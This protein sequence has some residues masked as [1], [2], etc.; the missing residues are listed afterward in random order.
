MDPNHKREAIGKLIEVCLHN[1]GIEKVFTLTFDN[2]SANNNVIAYLKRK[3]VHWKNCILDA[4]FLHIRCSAHIVNLIV[5]EG[6]KELDEAIVSIRNAVRYVRSSPSRL[7]KFKECISQ[8]KIDSKSLVCLD[9]PTKW[10]STYLML[11]LDLKFQKAFERMGEEDGHYASYF[12]ED[13]SSRKKVGPPLA[14]HWDDAKVF[15][16]FLKGFYDVTL[17]FSVSLHVS[18]NIHFHQVSS[19]QKQL[20]D[21]CVSEDDR[22]CVMARKMREKYNKYWGSMGNV[23]KLLLIAAVLDPRYKLDYVSFS[24]G[25]LYDN[26]ESR[27][28]KSTN[29]LKKTLMRL[30]NWYNEK[31]MGSNGSYQSSTGVESSRTSL[32]SNNSELEHVNYADQVWIAYLKKREQSQCKEVKN[33]VDRYLAD[34]CESDL[35]KD[36]DILNWWRVNGEKYPVLEKIAKDVYLHCGFRECF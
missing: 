7:Q 4:D 15:V 17:K 5:C 31:E 21:L 11:E 33:D 8:E 1:W 26:D 32:D 23:N 9:V 12:G 10:N 30:Y 3:M 6:L 2:A 19:I 28:P 36:F 13:D 34:P 22:L 29:G 35:I 25:M 27:V 16:K 18:S 24:Y 14:W 20:D